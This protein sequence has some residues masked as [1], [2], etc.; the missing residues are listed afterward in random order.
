MSDSYYTTITM[1]KEEYETVA[2][3]SLGPAP[4]NGQGSGGY[5]EQGITIFYD[6]TADGGITGEEWYTDDPNSPFHGATPA[7]IETHY[8]ENQN[9]NFYFSAWGNST[10]ADRDTFVKETISRSCWTL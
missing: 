6:P 7:E 4:R 8:N 5:Y 1:T 3:Y 2:G 9:L 10:T